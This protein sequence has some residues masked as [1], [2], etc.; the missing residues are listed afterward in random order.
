MDREYR[1]SEIP[2]LN[3]GNVDE[4]VAPF[5]HMPVTDSVTFGDMYKNMVVANRVALEEGLLERWSIDR[6]VLMGDAIHKVCPMNR[7]FELSS[8]TCGFRY[9]LTLAK[10]A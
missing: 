8:L 4:H 3:K 1:A 5:L 10:A 7:S 9:R 6:I 2:R